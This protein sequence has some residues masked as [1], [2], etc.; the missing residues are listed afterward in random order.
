[1]KELEYPFD[2]EYLLKK[3]KTL[4]KE[5][6]SQSNNLMNKN[7]AILGGS[8]TNDIKLIL[9]LFLLN[10]GIK[11][12]FYESEYNQFWQDATFKN[13]ELEDFQPDIIFIHTS[14]RNI[15]NYPQ[16]T[17]TAETIDHMLSAEMAKY[18]AMWDRIS[19]VYHCPIIQNNF[20]YPY[21][22]LLGNKDAS[23]IHGK[24]NYI[25]RLNALFYK[26]AQDNENFI[27]SLC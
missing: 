13:N 2:S 21:Y 10:Y 11:P 18:S 22:R 16:L 27:S 12:N 25:T 5:L 15:L 14:N 19:R 4:K 3:K 17:D 1:M 8:T 7:I 24:I 26:Y 23:D 6:L 9:E 20:E